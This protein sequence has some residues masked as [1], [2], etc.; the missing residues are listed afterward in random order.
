MLK[1]ENVSKVYGGGKRAVDHISFDIKKGEFIVFI[2]PSGCSKTTTMKMIN[3]IIKPTEGKILINGQDVM[4]KDVVELRR[5][6]GYVI[7]QIGLF[8]HM[9]IR[10]NIALVP[11]L[12]KWPETE[13]SARAEEL[14]QLVNMPPE[15]L[16]RYPFELSGGQQQRIG[17]LR[18][19]AVEPPLILMDEPFGALDTIT[20]DSL[21][22]EF[23]HLQRKLGKTII[24]VTHD[25]DEALKLAD[26]I[27]ILRNGQIVQQGTPNEILL[28]P[29][30]EFVEDFIGKERLTQARQNIQTV[31]QI[32]LHDPV[33]IQKNA[34]LSDAIRLMRKR[35]V[36]SLLVIDSKN[37]LV[38]YLNVELIERERNMEKVVF[39]VMETNIHLAYEDTLLRDATR[40][41]SI[42]N[43]KYLPVVDS[44]NHLIGIL[45][46]TNLVDAIYESIWGNEEL[47]ESIIE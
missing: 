29:A 31:G 13:R 24:F 27:F 43:L 16:N 23:K 47:Q 44:E 46:K 45:T 22:Q 15:Y 7:Q 32:M 3:R 11:K 5:S 30:N 18:A 4:K 26:R 41:I 10:E 8:P 37:S 36:D 20:R 40:E 2:G 1:F 39:E 34:L 42:H 17:V 33:T 6:I 12:L 19:L 38:G 14:L 9:T 28:N 25:I 21:Q 35:R